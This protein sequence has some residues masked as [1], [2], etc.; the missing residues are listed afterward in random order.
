[1]DLHPSAKGWLKNVHSYQPGKPIE[2]LQRELGVRSVVKLASNENALGPSPKAVAAARAV[3]GNLHR[4]PDGGCFALRNKLARHLRV[5]PDQLVFGNGSD[6]LLVFAVRAFAGKG[7]EIVIADPTFLIYEIAGQAENAAVVKVPMKDFHYDLDAM[8]KAVTARTKLVFIANPDNPV[9]TIVTEKALTRFLKTL[10]P[11]V[12]V[13]LDEAYFEFAQ[14]RRTYPH[15]LKLL[16]QF[17]N[18]VVTRT[19]SKA[20]GLAGL[21]VG[22]AVARADVA[23]ALSK[24][25]EPF[26][27]NLPAQAAALAALDDARHLRRTLRLVNKGRRYLTEELEKL[28]GRCLDTATNFVLSD[29]GR[30]TQP[31]YQALLKKGVIVRPMKA[32]GLP[33]F[34]RVTIGKRDENRRFVQALREVL[35]SSRT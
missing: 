10:P 32:W 25:R 35:A 16:T 12:I 17:P 18:L 15:S 26:N 29:L 28:G 11:R 13:V 20:Y 30:D 4:Y 8:R 14:E 3:L 31:L 2:E 7:D 27:V 22:Y 34:I 1:M 6:E 9:G 5:S 23:A 21:R 24:V 33:T 19:F